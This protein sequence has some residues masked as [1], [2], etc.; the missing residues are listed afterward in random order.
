[1][2]FIVADFRTYLLVNSLRSLDLLSVQYVPVPIAARSKARTVFG[3][4]NIGIAGSNSAR[5][6]DVCLCFSVLCG[7]VC[8]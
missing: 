7:P 2:T 1:V 3:R 6:M 8:R 4:S 5:G